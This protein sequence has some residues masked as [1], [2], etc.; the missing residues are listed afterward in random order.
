MQ[1]ILKVYFKVI[2]GTSLFLLA[3]GVLGFIYFSSYA[4]WEL[5]ALLLGLAGLTAELFHQYN[6]SSEYA[7]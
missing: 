6:W 2:V 3:A 5:G 4:L 1:E 7:K